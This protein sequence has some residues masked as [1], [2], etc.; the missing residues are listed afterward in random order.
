MAHPGGSVQWLNE[1]PALGKVRIIIN[2]SAEEMTDEKPV[3]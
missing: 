1:I 2:S 3:E